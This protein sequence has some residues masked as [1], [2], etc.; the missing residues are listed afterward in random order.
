MDH[1]TVR[2]GRHRVLVVSDFF[3]PNCGGVENHIYQLSQCL[4][5]RGHKVV[6]LTHAYGD[7]TGVRY[8]TNG[9]KVYHAPRVP[10]YQQSTFPTLY[11]LFPLL[12]VILLRER[13]SL[14]HGHQAFSNLAH[15]ALLHART[16]GYRVAFTDHSLFGFADLSSIL[17]NKLLK[18]SLADCQHLRQPHKKENTVLRACVPP[19]RVSVIPNAVDA[20]NFTP[21]PSARQRD[22]ITA[23]VLSRMMY[24][25]GIDLLA[26]CIPV[27]LRQHPHVK[28]VIGGDGPKRALLEAMVE[29]EGLHDRVELLGAVPHEEARSVLT[30]GHIFINAS[31]TEAFCMAIVEAASAGLLVVATA[32][33]GVPEVLPDG[34]VILCEPSPAA[35]V[36]AVA[37]AVQ[38]VPGVDPVEQHRQVRGMY[39][40]ASVAERV[41]AV[42]DGIA[43]MRWD[44]SLLGRLRRMHRCGTWAGKLFCAVVALDCLYLRWLEWWRPA[45]TIPPAPDCCTR[46]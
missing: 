26:A 2:E 23:V 21:D 12:R 7:R 41:E 37:V 18:F 43:A 3:Y 1:A 36:Q 10:F 19:N 8:L 25:K 20:T 15:E 5:A 29:E 44:H 34:M 22:T 45:A 24:R 30:R 27:I 40:W 32:V 38:R 31:L 33:G 11:G 46:A 14:V 42:Y 35:L 9:L 16:M 13:I 28:F 4:M 39:T 6:V 17:M